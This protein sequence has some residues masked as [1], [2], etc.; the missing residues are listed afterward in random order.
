MKPWPG[1]S[2]VVIYVRHRL[3]HSPRAEQ[4]TDLAADSLGGEEGRTLFGVSFTPRAK[5]TAP[6]EAKW[7]RSSAR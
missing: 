3:G 7:A 2:P 1:V 5:L 6:A 4:A